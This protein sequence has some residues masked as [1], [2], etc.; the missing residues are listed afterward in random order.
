[1]T[2]VI[3]CMILSQ[4]VVLALFQRSRYHKGTPG[5]R[6]VWDES[7]QCWI[8]EP[9]KFDCLDYTEE[10]LGFLR[11]FGIRSYQ[12]VGT[13]MS[14]GVGHSWVGI[15]VFGQI[16][17]LEPQY[18]WFFDPSSEFTGITVNYGSWEG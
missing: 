12:V 11:T 8:E 14:D 10:M 1:M 7:S 3:I 5:Y 6:P 13:D 16:W 2:L 15:D 9:G 18:L 4:F 17:H